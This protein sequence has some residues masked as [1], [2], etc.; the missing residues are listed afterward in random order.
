ME[1]LVSVE[2]E[3]DN[4]ETYFGIQK[5]RFG[6]RLNLHI[7][8]DP[9]EYEMIMN[10][11]IPKLTLQPILENSII[12]GTELKIG[13]GNLYIRFACTQ[14]RLIICIS[15]DG[16]G[17]D[18]ETLAALNHK[19]RRGNDSI[20][21]PEEKKGRNCP[22]ECKQS[23]SFDFWGM[24]TVCIFILFPGGDGCGDYDSD[25]VK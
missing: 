1:N 4:C 13:A 15:D 7:E 20:G 16:V 24:S 6:D 3:L 17:M 22:G 2:E 14:D 19:L 9:G 5:Y 10:C 12:H 23:D 8:Y 25:H 18:E 21:S 11:R